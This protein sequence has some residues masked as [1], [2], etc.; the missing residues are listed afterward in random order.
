MC[1]RHQFCTLW[2]QASVWQTVIH[3]PLCIC[4]TDSYSLTT[5]TKVWQTVI[6]RPLCISLTD[7]YSLTTYTNVWQTV[8][9]RPL[10]ISLTDSYSLTT[11]TK[12]W[13][14]VTW[15]IRG[16]RATITRTDYYRS[17]TVSGLNLWNNFHN[18]IKECAF[19]SSF[20]QSLYNHMVTKPHF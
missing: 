19:L 7:S 16:L 18:H 12:V 4:L 15:F 5:Y 9:H 8:I 11:Y 20:K 13:K 10:C 6:H 1:T 3:R 14:T 17:V 2:M